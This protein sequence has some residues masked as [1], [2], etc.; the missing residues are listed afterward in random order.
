MVPNVSVWVS[1][2]HFVLCDCR[3]TSICGGLTFRG[4]LGRM[5]GYGAIGTF[6][7]LM[8]LDILELPGGKEGAGTVVPFR[9]RINK[10][11]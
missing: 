10:L 3:N 7:L 2:R 6:K 1:M 8:N 5:M 9:S 4:G 11:R